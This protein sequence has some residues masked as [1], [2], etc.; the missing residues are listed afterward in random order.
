MTPESGDWMTLT[1]NLIIGIIFAVFTLRRRTERRKSRPV[2][3]TAFE[4]VIA[5][6]SYLADETGY[7][8]RLGVVS[9]IFFGVTMT[10]AGLIILSHTPNLLLSPLVGSIVGG[11]VGGFFFGI[12]FP[13]TLR[14]KVNSYTTGLYRGE[15][16]IAT[17]PPLGMKPDYQLPCTRIDGRLGIGG[18]LCAGRE[19]LVF[20]PHKLNR[21]KVQPVT[22]SPI[23]TLRTE[24]AP[25][26]PRNFLQ[27][28]LVPKPQP[29]L[30]ITSQSDTVYLAVPQP[31]ATIA[32]LDHVLGGLRGNRD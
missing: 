18:T 32:K 31:A 30:T 24:L 22:M 15:D 4:N 13:I 14:R 8:G 21:R 2:G 29:Q 19:A 6:E 11:L 28:L 27:K 20:V 12:F 1:Q 3:S 17:I 23:A 10:A 9:G 26:A 7:W 16:W 5:L 25:S